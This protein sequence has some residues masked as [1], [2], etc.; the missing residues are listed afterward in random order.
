MSNSTGT[1]TEDILIGTASSQSIL[2][3]G[4]DD[5]IVGKDGNDTL[6]GGKGS[7]RILSGGGQNLLLG[8]EG[9]DTLVASSSRASVANNVLNGGLGNDLIVGNDNN[10]LLVGDADDDIILGFDG[11]DNISGDAGNDG[12]NGGK[13]NDRVLGGEGD[14]ELEGGDGDDLVIGGN[15]SDLI[16]GLE[17]SDTLTGGAGTDFFYL[18]P[19]TGQDVITDFEDGV[20]KLVL[21]PT[22]RFGSEFELSA[23]PVNNGTRIILTDTNETLAILRGIDPASIDGNDSIANGEPGTEPRNLSQLTLEELL[24][25]VNTEVITDRSEEIIQNE[26]ESANDRPSGGSVT[27]QGVTTINAEEARDRF[28]VDGNG[29]TVGVISDSFDRSQLDSITAADDIAT[30]DLPQ[31]E[32]AVSILGDSADNSL[33]FSIPNGLIST[34]SDEGRALSQI[35]TDVAPGANILFRTAFNGADDFASGIDE[36]VAAG[37]DIIVDDVSS[38]EEPFFQDGVIAQAANRA[39]DAGVPYF[40]SAGNSNRN[41]YEAEFKPVAENN[42][43]FLDSER[44]RFHDFNPEAAVDLTQN[45]T[46]QPGEPVILSV[47][48]DEPFASAGGKGTSNDLDVF[49]LDANN[50]VVS[51]SARSNVGGDAVEILGYINNTDSAA[52]YQLAIAQDTTAGGQAPNLIKYIELFGGGITEA[53]YFNNSATVFGQQNA[54]NTSG[55][56][57]VFYQ[58]PNEL[59]SFSSVGVVPILFDQQG[60][61]LSE[62]EFRQKPDIVA[63]DGVNTTF[64]G[65]SDEENDGFPNFFGTSAASPHAAG[66]AALLLEAVPDATPQEIYG[67]LEQTA[68][69]LDDPFTP[70]FDTGYDTATGFGL[71]QADLALDNLLG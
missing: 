4:G 55:V 69:D 43:D 64:F 37:A 15:G 49:I 3:F 53:E 67:A 7:D 6:I 34:L 24:F 27:S 30:E 44:Y 9:N 66:V 2:G 38:F 63:P 28:G 56:G 21:T 16:R 5:I 1:Q 29:V 22:P 18:I 57:A 61:R 13:G 71:I 60:N 51:V 39:V 62:P 19:N 23:V 14:D 59:E 11:R 50:N 35:V 20:D 68:I 12:I 58:T 25:L 32:G 8:N 33:F 45:F 41:S 52:E 42:F 48:W 70:E 10:S 47:Q 31:G 65:N 46:L 26:E 54:E 40:T 36:L 17:G